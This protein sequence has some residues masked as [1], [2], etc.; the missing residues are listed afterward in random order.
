MLA[1]VELTPPDFIW[2]IG[3]DDLEELLAPMRE[4]APGAHG[5]PQGVCRSAGGIGQNV[6]S[7]LTRLVCREPLSL[8]ALVPAELLH[9]PKSAE[10]DA[11]G[12]VIRSPE[13]LQPLTL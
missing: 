8:L 4:S 7:L 12:L 13:A 10:V 6:S 9:I 3:L 5:L 1:S 2:K 11:Q